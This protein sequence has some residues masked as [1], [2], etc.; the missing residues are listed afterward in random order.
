MSTCSHFR[1]HTHVFSLRLEYVVRD[2]F[3]TPSHTA[4]GAPTL[5]NVL[6]PIETEPLAKF[7]PI[8]RAITTPKLEQL[9]AIQLSGSITLHTLGMK[10]FATVEALQW[11]PSLLGREWQT[12]V[13]T[14]SIHLCSSP[15]SHHFEYAEVFGTGGN[16]AY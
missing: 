2:R 5:L 1:D 13:T 3:N 9:V 7:F 6:L 14:L 10:K 11:H 12:T 8:G 4:L 15:R 16:I